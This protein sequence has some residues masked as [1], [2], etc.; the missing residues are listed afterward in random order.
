[1]PERKPFHCFDCDHHGADYTVRTRTWLQAWPDYPQ[2]KA[3]LIEKYGKKNPKSFL[4]LCLKCLERRLG[5]PLTL[6]DFPDAPINE[7]VFLGARMCQ[8]KRF[9][10][11]PV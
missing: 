5:R 10:P 8:E 1:M 4:S 6:S 11:E 9:R 3:R 7:C 2:E